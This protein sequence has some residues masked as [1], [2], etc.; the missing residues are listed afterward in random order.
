MVVVVILPSV[1][2]AADAD[3]CWWSSSVER[4][5]SHPRSGETVAGPVVVGSGRCPCVCLSVVM[6]R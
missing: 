6:P 4:G 5:N 3:S 1:A 2:A